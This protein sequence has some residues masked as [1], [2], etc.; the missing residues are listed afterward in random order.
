MSTL[1]NYRIDDEPDD[2]KFN[3]KN[4]RREVE[5]NNKMAGELLFP[6]LKEF[7]MRKINEAAG[8]GRFYTTVMLP[9]DSDCVE[10]VEYVE[11][12]FCA[13]GFD[14]TAD[15]CQRWEVNLSW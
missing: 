12:V 3:A 7:V 15:K 8:F 13:L 1:D 11:G 10:A 9:P 6:G 5:R 4:L 2:T 14:V